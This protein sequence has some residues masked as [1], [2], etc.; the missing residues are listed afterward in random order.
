MSAGHSPGSGGTFL[1]CCSG[2][3]PLRP[4]SHRLSTA[5]G[6]QARLW[7]AARR[8]KW[9]LVSGHAI[10][11]PRSL[12]PQACPQCWADPC[13]RAVWGLQGLL[14]GHVLD[15][16]GRYLAERQDGL[17]D[18]EP[19]HSTGAEGCCLGMKVQVFTGNFRDK[20]CALLGT[21]SLTKGLLSAPEDGLVRLS[22]FR[23]IGLR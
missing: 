16:G 18:S 4:T 15:W 3:H 17:A 10:L 5:C 13:S 19:P 9:A 7:G 23:G 2:H 11:L 8:L 20:R 14:T 1:L 22:F 6:R 12:G 21:H